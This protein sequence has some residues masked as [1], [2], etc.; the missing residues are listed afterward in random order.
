MAEPKYPP[1]VGERGVGFWLRWSNVYASREGIF[2]SDCSNEWRYSFGQPDPPDRSVPLESL[3]RQGKR[4]KDGLRIVLLGDTGEGDASQYGLTPLLRALN[5]DFM[6]INGDVANPAGRINTEAPG[7]DDFQCGFFEPYKHFPCAIW[8]TPG[9]HEYYSPDC[10]KAFYQVFCTR[11][12]DRRWAEAGLPHEVLQPGTYWEVSDLDGPSK[13][14]IIGLDTGATGNLDGDSRFPWRRH[15]DRAQIAWLND[16]LTLADRLEGRVVILFHIPPLSR[17]VQVLRSM[18]DLQ[19]VIASHACVKLVLCGH[20]HNHQQYSP[21]VYRRFLREKV[22]ATL[23]EGEEYPHYIICG[24]GGSAL[25]S[26]DFSKDEYHADLCYPDAGK[27]REY[28]GWGKKI[29]SRAGFNTSLFSLLV[30]ILDE[31]AKAD[32]D[33]CKYRSLMVLDI[34]NGGRKVTA[35]PVFLND[36]MDLFDPDSP[37]EINVLDED[38]KVILPKVDGCIQDKHSFEI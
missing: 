33:A 24:G 1:F 29:V 10:G 37:E 32:A 6:I 26:T 23:T 38:P 30:N 13:L 8:A 2:R 36:V 25:H 15:P 9:N 16:R 3:L 14:L 20:E 22:N 17:Q 7:D 31:N 35:K 28:L 21:A 18:R 5:P 34:E 4:V 19:L 27:W 11:A 12:F